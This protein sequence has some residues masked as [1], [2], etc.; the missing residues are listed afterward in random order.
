VVTYDRQGRERTRMHYVRGT[1]ARLL[2]PF[3]TNGNNIE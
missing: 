3:E 2:P 1:L